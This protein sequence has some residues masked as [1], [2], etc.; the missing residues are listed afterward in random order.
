MLIARQD[1]ESLSGP[2]AI[3]WDGSPQAGRAV[4]AAL[5]LLAMASE[6]LTMTKNWMVSHLPAANSCQAAMPN[7]CSLC[8]AITSATISML[9]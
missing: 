3:A 4:K 5:P 1:A 7:K 8:W 2:A 9:P 6:M